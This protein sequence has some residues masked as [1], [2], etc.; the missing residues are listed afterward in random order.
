MAPTKTIEIKMA[1][2]ILIDLKIGARAR[3]RGLG[4]TQI[5]TVCDWRRVAKSGLQFRNQ[6][7][8]NLLGG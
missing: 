2:C 8:R 1:C 5:T 6:H 4:L 3:T 7:I